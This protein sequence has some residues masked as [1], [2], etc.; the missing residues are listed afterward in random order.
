MA[1]CTSIVRAILPSAPS[2]KKKRKRAPRKKRKL[3]PRKSPKRKDKT[4]RNRR[5]N[6]SR[7]NQGGEAPTMKVTELVVP[8]RATEVHCE[9]LPCHNN[10]PHWLDSRDGFFVSSVARGPAASTKSRCPESLCHSAR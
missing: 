7:P 5:T 4:R 8:R 6:L 3:P 2:V 1:E 10:L 9:V